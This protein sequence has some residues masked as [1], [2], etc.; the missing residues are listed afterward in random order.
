MGT[1]FH[2]ITASGVIPNRRASADG[3]PNSFI[4][5]CKASL[6]VWRSFF[7]ALKLAMVH[8]S[9]LQWR[10]HFHECLDGALKTEPF[11]S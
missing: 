3:P 9:G 11:A 4:A 2:C 6:A 10:K 1:S 5:I 8:G 7:Y